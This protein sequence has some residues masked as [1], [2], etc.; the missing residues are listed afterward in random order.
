MAGVREGVLY[1]CDFVPDTRR[2]T[3]YGLL[4]TPLLT[5]HDEITFQ[6]VV[7]TVV[8]R[9]GC[10]VKPHLFV[11]ENVKTLRRFLLLRKAQFQCS[12]GAP[13]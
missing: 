11:D 10:R 9:S 1:L 8:S 2:K 5:R 13:R 6:P 12:F 7:R 3:R 4:G